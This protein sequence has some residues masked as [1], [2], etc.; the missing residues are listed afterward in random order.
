MQIQLPFSLCR[1]A[2]PRPRPLRHED[3]SVLIRSFLRLSCKRGRDH[4]GDYVNAMGRALPR[5]ISRA[6]GPLLAFLFFFT[7]PRRTPNNRSRSFHRRDR[8]QRF[9]QKTRRERTKINGWT[10][11]IRGCS[12]SRERLFETLDNR[13]L[14]YDSWNKQHLYRRMER[15]FKI[16]SIVSKLTP[17]RILYTNINVIFAHRT[18]MR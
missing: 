18:N 4:P 11:S 7:K 17:L 10:E 9:F 1:R 2:L 5:E 8:W 3:R 13:F 12:V 15:T 6:R 16:V 14:P